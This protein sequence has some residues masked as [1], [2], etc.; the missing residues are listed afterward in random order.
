MAEAGRTQTYRQVAIGS[1]LGDDFLL[2]RRATI[3]E[4]LGRM[5]HMEVDVFTDKGEVDF[6]KIVGTGVTIRLAH[7]GGTRFFHGFVT[8]IIHTGG[9]ER[10][11]HYRLT[12]SPWLWFLTRV[13]D[14]RFFQ[15]MKVP[16]IIKQV[17]SKRGFDD[18]DTDRLKGHYPVREY[19]VQYRETDF[20]FVSRLMEE[21][22]IYYFFTHEDNK[23][24]MVLADSSSSHEAYEGC[25]II[26]FF[27]PTE[28]DRGQEYVWDWQKEQEVQPGKYSLRDYNFETPG[29]DLSANATFPRDYA[30][31]N[32]EMF[33]CHPARYKTSA[34]GDALSKVRLEEH[35]AY[36][37][38]IRAT[39]DVRCTSCGCTFTLDGLNE[40]QDKEHLIT[41]VV[42]Q[43]ESDEYSSS[44]DG[45]SAAPVYESTF[46]AI[47]A[48]QQ[49]RPK[50]VTPKPMI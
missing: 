9:S 11:A 6:K 39:G 3:I 5:F 7:E 10:V 27:P 40:E 42:H 29:E 21:E 38:V 16:D 41:S 45:D 18:I 37:E 26:P 47:L 34:D 43:I 14:C 22:G 4:H 36:Y 23:H 46:T 19:C 44:A 12:L 28:A 35:Q 15:K 17:L 13:S 32:F 33:D 31:P 30:V 20:N 1:A 50:R 48:T 49:Y 24:T 25:E 8:R 2:F